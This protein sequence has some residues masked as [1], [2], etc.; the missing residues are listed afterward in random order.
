MHK[1]TKITQID[2]PRISFFHSLKGNVPRIGE[3]GV[4]VVEGELQVERLLRSHLTIETLFME[5][6]FYDKFAQFERKIGAAPRFS[7]S[8]KL[9]EQIL[10]YD[11]H[12]GVLALATRP[13][14]VL[15]RDLQPPVVI[16]NGICD[17]ENVG[18]LVRTSRAFGVRSLLV[19]GKSCDP[20]LRRAIRVSMGTV[21]EMSI[22]Y[23]PQLVPAIEELSS[24]LDVVAAER[25]AKAIPVERFSFDRNIAVVFG[26]ERFGV[27]AEV[28]SHC[29]HIV[30][31]PMD[32]SGVSSLNLNAA[33]AVILSYL[34][35]SGSSPAT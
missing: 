15:L 30:E 7:A 18:A 33:A 17:A 2:D 23:V 22:C 29:K 32:S 8:R 1:I 12:R 20:L 35:K 34:W 16:F 24:F 27:E 10:G 6:A 28:L 19:D 31:V 3:R 14:A 21:L 26:Q 11:L 25:H 9:M 4:I 13:P 5:D